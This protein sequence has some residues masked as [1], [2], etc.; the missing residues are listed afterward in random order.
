MYKMSNK[1]DP[2]TTQLSSPLRGLGG[3]EKKPKK[4]YQYRV[5]QS[6]RNDVFTLFMNI[7][8]LM[9]YLRTP[10]QQ[11]K[12]IKTTSRSKKRDANE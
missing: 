9:E 8:E 5:E 1:D 2:T 10:I 3:R 12:R 4:E 11:V 6:Y 7:D